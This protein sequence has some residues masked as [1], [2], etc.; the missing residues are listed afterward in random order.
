MINDPEK[1]KEA[2]EWL[3][4]DNRSHTGNWDSSI[5][6]TTNIKSPKA[7]A[8]LTFISSSKTETKRKTIDRQTDR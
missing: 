2:K 1:E 4:E 5:L 3:E 6:E 7:I 8:C